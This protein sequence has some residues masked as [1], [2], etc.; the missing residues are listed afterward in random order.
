M[1]R[2]DAD[3]MKRTKKIVR[4]KIGG[5]RS[6]PI[7]RSGGQRMNAPNMRIKRP[8]ILNRTAA[9]RRARQAKPQQMIVDIKNK[10]MPNPANKSDKPN[11]NGETK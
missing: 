11:R 9:S 7:K 8:T 2:T 10:T 4:R 3:E 6:T 1:K 5:T